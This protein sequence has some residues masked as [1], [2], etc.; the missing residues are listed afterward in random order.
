MNTIKILQKIKERYFRPVIFR[1]EGYLVHFGNCDVYRSIEVYGTAPCT[2]GFNCDLG[3]L[4]P[5]LIEKLN[6]KYY[7]E[8]SNKE[9]DQ[10]NPLTPEQAKDF[11]E[12]LGGKSISEPT[13]EEME[14]QDQEDWQIIAKVFGDEYVK[15][16]K[17][18]IEGGY[19]G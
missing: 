15:F 13:A 10:G 16:I 9:I 6:P 5:T 17:E 8:E 14:K 1:K 2:C 19:Y 4:W 12:K 11:F 3:L 7:L 18:R